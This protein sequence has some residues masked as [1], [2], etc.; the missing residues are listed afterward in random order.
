MTSQFPITPFD[1]HWE[2]VVNGWTRYSPWLNR[3][4]EVLAGYAP[5]IWAV[6]F[7]L[8]WFWPPL[9]Q[10]RA[11]RAVVYA[12]VAGVLAL[13][14]N[15]VLGHILPYRPRPFVYE[16]RLI[17]QLLP[18]KKDTSFPSDHAAGSFAFAVGL[19]FA[20]A[21]DGIL[22][23]IFAALVSI[24]RVFVGL[25]WPTDVIAGAVIGVIS[26]LVVL[27]LRGYLE[28]LV[29]A[30]FRLFGMKPERTYRRHWS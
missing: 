22:A 29:Q 2:L 24:A 9:K 8:L 18:H 25:H 28:W 3:L 10:N 4:G 6:V 17:H 1:Q 30:L 27:A 26:G 12:V 11:R 20:G 5:E 13:A 14:I 21:S 23:L 19:F 7:L 16:P 15:V